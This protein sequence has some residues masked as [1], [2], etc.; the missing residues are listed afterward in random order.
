LRLSPRDP[1]QRDERRL[2]LLLEGDNVDDAEAPTL[3]KRIARAPFA[4]FPR[5]A[6]YAQE[7]FTQFE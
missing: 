5:Y 3:P 1:Q 2:V 7:D 4:F 6:R